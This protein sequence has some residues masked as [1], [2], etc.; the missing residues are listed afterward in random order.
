MSTKI[1]EF[2]TNFLNFTTDATSPYQVVETCSKQ[3]AQAGFVPLDFDRPWELQP[4]G[5]YYTTLY[6]TTIFAFRLPKQITGTSRFRL[7]SSHTDHPGFRIKPNP[8]IKGKDI[9]TLNTETYGGAILNSWLD[10]PL[11]IA[12]KVTL[13]S[14]SLFQPES[15][16]LDFKRPLLTIPSL[17]IHMNPSVNSGVA[18]NKQTDLS[19]IFDT[20]P[21]DTEP[22]FQSFLADELSVSPDAI[23]DYDLS[24]YNAETGVLLGKNQELI[25]CPRLDNLTSV[26]ASIQGL[27]EADTPE[28]DIL[29]CACYNNEEVGSRT[30]QGA[31]S[32]LTSIIL[33]KIFHCCFDANQTFAS[34]LFR[35]FMISADVAHATHPNYKEKNDPTNFVLLNQGVALKINGNQKYATV[36]DAIGVVQQICLH[37]DIPFQKYV[38][39]S[40]IAGGSTLGS[41]SSAWLPM[42]TVDLGIPILAMHSA[43]ETAGVQDEYSLFCLLRAYFSAEE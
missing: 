6:D 26:Y 21:A 39:R 17:A 31:D 7:V 40:D 1:N 5:S 32:S 36:P 13:K 10:R 20:E 38:N 28:E 8:D 33:E 15:R 11:S 22:G 2:T 30:K 16:L 29:V 35:S 23:L 4:E 14:D 18:L 24:V 25:S 42:R 9:L 27:I 41:I 19:P 12:G 37:Y 3:F 43:R 34:A